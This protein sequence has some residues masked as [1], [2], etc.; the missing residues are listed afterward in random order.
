MLT[1]DVITVKGKGPG[2]VT[3]RLTRS[4]TAGLELMA[5]ER[6]TQPKVMRTRAAARATR[7]LPNQKPLNTAPPGSASASRPA[8]G[9]MG[10][11]V[12]RARPRMGYLTRRHNRR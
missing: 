10:E 2:K 4:P 11:T 9:V 5:S 7:R 6:P 1:R 3:A 12:L 8:P